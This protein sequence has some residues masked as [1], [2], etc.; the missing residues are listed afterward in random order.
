MYSAITLQAC[1]RPFG[2]N[3]QKSYKKVFIGLFSNKV[4]ESQICLNT[5]FNHALPDVTSS[6]FITI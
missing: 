6:L 3:A 4:L 5:Q 2:L 1:K